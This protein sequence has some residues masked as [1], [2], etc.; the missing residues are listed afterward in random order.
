MIE[1]QRFSHN[2]NNLAAR[3]VVARIYSVF[4]TKYLS[5]ISR[6]F[7]LASAEVCYIET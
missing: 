3:S 5:I 6:N 7:T 2:I 4:Y 1:E